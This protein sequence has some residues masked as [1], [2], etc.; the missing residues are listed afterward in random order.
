M[1]KSTI[2]LLVCLLVS[3]VAHAQLANSLRP[4]GS[5]AAVR[6]DGADDKLAVTGN[7]TIGGTFTV[8]LW[9]KP[10][11]VADSH[12]I[13]G[14]RNSPNEYSF[15]IHLYQDNVIHADIGNGSGWATTEAR[16]AFDYTTNS[17]LYIAYVV[18]P[19]NYTVYANGKR[20]GS[21]NYNL[22]TPV[23][24]DANH[25]LFIGWS[26][27]GKEF[28][29]GE[30][31]EVRIWNTALRARR[32]ANIWNHNLPL[33]QPGLVLCY[34]FDEGS[35]TSV[36]DVSGNGN[37]GTLL[38]GVSWV[39]P[40][41]PALV[42]APSGGLTFSEVRYDGRLA[43]EEALFTLSVDAVATANGESSAPLLEGDVAVLPARLP[44]AL[45]IVRDGNRYLLVASRPGHFQFKLEVVAKIQ[46][47]EPWN[48]VWFT[49]PSATIASVTAQAGGTNTEVELLKG[50]L[51]ESF[52]TN[53]VS[54]VRGF[55]GAEPT[56]AV[57][58][59]G[60]VMEVARKALLT[61]DSTFTAQL[62]PV[63][64]KYTSKFH[65]DVVQ[66]NA[67]QLTLMLP[68]TQALTRLEGEQVR[69]WHSVVE[70][71]HQTLTIEFIKP[72]EKA[73]DLTL[74]SEQAVESGAAN[75]SMNPPQP[76]NVERESGSLTVSAEDTLVEIASL[77]GLRQVNAPDNAVAAYR[78][79]ARPFTLA[80]KLKPIEPVINVTDRVNA[81]LE[82]TRLVISH[83]LALDVEKAGIYT[84]ELTPQ[85]GFA[86]AD[87]RGEGV[88]DW[89]VSDGKL[90][91]SFSA[92]VLGPRRLEVQLE[93][94]LKNFPEQISVLPLRVTGAAKETAQIG[95]ASSPGIRLRTG[96]LS[97]LR[98]IPVNRLPD[99]ADEILAY[100]AEQPDWQL[101]VAS[102]RLAAR[103][104]A[105]VFNLVTI[106]D[107]IVGGSATIR[108][109][110]VNQGVQEFKVRVPAQCKNVEFTGPNIR[111][112]ELSREPGDASDTNYV[113]WTIGLQDKVWGGYTL[114]V[115]YDYQFD[116]AKADATL[117]VGGIHT[118]EVERETGSIAITTAGNLQLNPKT[119][120]DAL[121]RVDETELSPADRSFI[122]RAVVQA[123]QYTGNEYDLALD[124]KRYATES[125]L[126]A[127]ADRTQITSVL[128]EAG[129]MLTQASFM[130]KNNEK[131]FQRF[132]LPKDS[133][134][135]G[136]YVNG[137]PAKP[138]RDND[139]VLVPL[140]RDVD[141][142]QAFA[143]DIMYAQTNGALASHWSKTL[144]LN[145]PRTDV[146]NTYAEWQLFVP[147]SFRLSH[148]GG[149]M[150]IAQGTTYGLL[151][152]WWKFLAFYGEVLR[153][154]GGAILFIGLLALLVI[155]LV[156]SAVRRGW[157]GILTL[158]A[159][160]AILF[161]LAAML[162]PALS[163][164]KRKAQS[165][166]S[167]NNL[168]QIGIAARVFAG[169]NNNRLPVS[170]DEMKNELGTD[171]LT[172]DTETG[173]R[174]TYLGGGL[175]LAALK[176]DSVLAYSPIVNGHCE[177]LYADGSVEQM[178]AGRF[179]ELSQRGL[180]Q[181]ATPQEIAMQQQRQ[182]ITASE[183]PNQPAAASPGGV[184][185]A[186][187]VGYVNG[188]AGGRGGGFGGSMSVEAPQT[189]ASAGLPPVAAPV[190]APQPAVA[191]IRSLRIELPQTGQ[192]FLF[193]KVLN[194]RDEP[195]SIRARIMSLHT[196]QTLQMTWQT[197]AFLIGLSVWWWQWRRVDRNSF[198]LTVALALIIGSVCSL[199][200]Q[201]RALHDA[202]IVGFPV[203]TLAIMAWLVWRYW[204]R[205]DQPA[206]TKPPSL[207]PP[208]PDSSLP[209]VMASIAIAFLLGSN[210]LSAAPMDNSSFVIRHSSIISAS[211]SGTVNDRV[212]LLDA[213][214]QISAAKAGEV[215]PLFGDDVAVQQFTVK[216]GSAELVRDGDNIAVQ[217][218]SRGNVTLQV[219][220]LVK[221]AGDVTKRWLTFGIPP[222]LSSQVAL[223]LGEAG[224]DVDFPTAISFKRILDK[225]KTR[226]EAVIGSGD[227]IELV[228]T[229]RVKRAAEVAATVFCQNASLV[230]FGGGVVNVR[231][232]L[233]YQIT[234]G[235]LRQAQVQLPAGQR[236]LRVEGKEIRTWETRN[237]NG[238]PVLV[239]DLLK[240][241]SSSWKLTV[242]TETALDALPVTEPV[243]VPH[244]LDVKRE[245][246]LVALQGTEELGLSVESASG[247]ERVDA[248]EFARAGADQTGRLFSVFRFSNPEFA[249]R[250]RAEIVQPE[251]EA[252]AR[253]NFRVSAEQVALSATID[254]TIKRAG[255]F[256]L[257]VCLP[258]G[259]RVERVTGNNILQQAEHNDS[260]PRVLE[261][262]LKDRTSGAY[263]LGIELTR[264]FKEL[265]RSLVIASVHPLDTAKLTGFV[266]VSAEP[267]VAVKTESFD[268]L[269]EIP[270]VSL[271]DYATVAGSGSVLAYKF[272]SSE[273][274]SAPEWNLSVATEAVAAWARADIVNTFTFGETL[275]SGRAL[276]RYD[277]ANAPVKELRVKVPPEFK[278]VEIS[279]PNIRSR[280]QDG[281]VWRVE[282]QSP[283]RGFYVLTVTW[284][285]PR[286]AKAGTMEL[287][288][289][290]AEGVERE[291]GLLAISVPQSGTPL[292]VSELNVADLQRVDTGDF[293]DW[294]GSP[295][296]A[297][298]LAY[299]YARPGYKLVLN[300]QRFDEAEVLQALVDNA[301]FTSVVADDGQMMTEVSLSVRNNGRQ[302]LEIELPPGAT[303]W[304]A[305]VAGQPVRPSL[306]EGKLLLP[307]Q[308]S[309]ADDGAMSV[310]LTYVGTNTF[311]RA[312][313]TVGFVSPKFDV[314]LKNARW[315]IYLPPDY[316]YQAFQGTMTREA[317]APAASSASF[318]SLDYWR[319]E[320]VSKEQAKVETLRDV[321]EAQRQLASGNV[322]EASWSFNRARVKSAKGNGE[323][324]DVKQ[325]EKDLQSA[326]ASN[327]IN[328]QSD[329]SLRNSGQINAD[330]NTPVQ[331]GKLYLSY[332]NAAAEQQ[333]A[334]LQQAQEIVAAQVQPLHVNLP[335]RGVHYAFAQ[336]LQTETGKPMTIQM[337][338]VNTKAVSWPKR[339][340]T[341]MVAFLVLWVFVAIIS[342]VTRRR[343]PT[344]EY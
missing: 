4:P 257:R 6:F 16:G 206:P 128:T 306:R 70:G 337:L 131:Q 340:L 113:A 179:A 176:P 11:D 274:K 97:G 322:R 124:V 217:L 133:K 19:T 230:T 158:L 291:T 57:R 156:I 254:Y 208:A 218:N 45:K 20:V 73:Y 120:S 333:S 234:Q 159:V 299:R 216:N 43:D 13:L 194:I 182:A 111:R 288:G 272:I 42:S 251:I 53:G 157:N 268:G 14:S 102:E 269:T 29:K 292:Q 295:D 326:Q 332:D 39:R 215:V 178:T 259:Y 99:R 165:I 77:A 190:A 283:T 68:A 21:G 98:E 313:G 236:L 151:D 279:G 121:H 235:E 126:E 174:Y 36:H 10:D 153:E 110:L 22:T 108:Y 147:P 324:E 148:F 140:P 180:V 278:N 219:K 260:G 327:L 86:V 280:E 282:L 35:G 202:L 266:S 89:K 191:G 302:F 72:V 310:E 163:A 214:L 277:I 290:S 343:Q 26:G 286:P 287:T 221:I 93:Q 312:R 330:E 132:Q 63:V 173:Q 246:G 107:G 187:V 341:M 275:L 271:P 315:E 117:S 127:V 183:L 94:A 130:V 32:I 31:A 329:F 203:V 334:K 79:N 181:P 270:A 48:T 8:E 91:M 201:W 205:G 125:V 62:T 199:L 198:I 95:A 149:S 56:V 166:N 145:A 17:W 136:C 88:E 74:Y 47:E 58:W 100:T 51:L 319:M 262:T 167:V 252:V 105:D 213:T 255:L 318:S 293:P 231:A 196:F 250:V 193:T 316:D 223:A 195:L 83:G 242:E 87:V 119:V 25:Q 90:R 314:P 263:T 92:R 209:P 96:T 189:G 186:G 307:I 137:Q 114:V 154:A 303:N 64:I 115:T 54:G 225:D 311:P 155:A 59:Q 172:Y 265:P 65:Y 129:E 338:A 134:L 150:N 238:A 171:K 37:D 44:D 300:V 30:V 69:D 34:R 118:A 184:Y 304:S 50:T 211:Y 61:V 67:A 239:V 344:A 325:L 294:A 112:K 220:M 228:W 224:A 229:P 106:G 28:F 237:E 81:R 80:L 296:T 85:S 161:V 139:W 233:D 23:L 339:G 52:R 122:T 249:L 55:L 232:T 15:D 146:P 256:A 285:Q 222:A 135:W 188:N 177:V 241:V 168:H 298:A 281:N 162:L 1:K 200:V 3:T 101:S 40:N 264:S 12:G 60:K 309:G 192:P 142:D 342:N 103:V 38:N 152:A 197:V 160:M 141:H 289:V 320:Q 104:V 273:P 331:S 301:Q 175:S 46:R 267:G 258:D 116:P 335:V 144:E 308:Q 2:A 138:E 226:V 164:A 284:D 66:G 169:D 207:K 33:P 276:V 227:H 75:S 323:G 84:L 297:T 321:N 7:S 243:A 5:G 82:E 123:W 305:F 71:D 247:L 76:L 240:G 49:G 27:F 336:V 78:F 143:V 244:A 24:R 109:S 41:S 253:N 261:V 170:F 204:P 18:T 210:S 185:S 317:A 248:E 9:A 212:A 245:T 328:A